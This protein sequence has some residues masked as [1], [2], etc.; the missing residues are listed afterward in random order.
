M[1]NAAATCTTFVAIAVVIL[2]VLVVLAWMGI[3]GR[4]EKM[5]VG[6]HWVQMGTYGH[7]GETLPA[8]DDSGYEITVPTPPWA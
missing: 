8:Y 1:A 7:T 4:G 6:A 3:V 2:I 5:A